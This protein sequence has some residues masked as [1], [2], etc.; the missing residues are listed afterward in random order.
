MAQRGKDSREK[1]LT[2]AEKLIL[3]NGFSGTSLDQ[4][5]RESHISKGGFFYHFKSKNE[6]A[7]ALFEKYIVDDKR[8]FSG[9]FEQAEN[10]TED[11]LQQMLIFVKLLADSMAA[12]PDVHP[13]CLVASYTYESQQF[14]SDIKPLAQESLRVW[15]VLFADHL[16][17]ITVQYRPRMEVDI[18]ELATLLCTILEGGIIVSRV[19][20]DQ[21]MLVQQIL[22]YRSHLRLL[23]DPA[24]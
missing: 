17:R 1:I 8:F 16:Q 14:E 5:I 13:G 4:V 15:Q 19:L 20:A 10:L 12:L 3:A 7:L 6:L 24:L 23:F 11:P 18:E 21:G 2:V 9:L 22:H